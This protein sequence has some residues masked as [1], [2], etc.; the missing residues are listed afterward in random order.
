MSLTNNLVSIWSFNNS[1]NDVHGSNHGSAVGAT[2]DETNKKLGVASANVDG[3]DDYINCGNN[4]SVR[5]ASAITLMAGVRREGA[6][7][8]SLPGVITINGGTDVATGYILCLTSAGKVRFYI[9]NGSFVYAESNDVLTNGQWHQIFARW[10]G[11]EVALWIDNVKQTI[12]A[13]SAGVTYTGAN[14]LNIG[15]YNRQ[16]AGSYTDGQLDEC[17]L[18]NRALTTDEMTELYNSGNWREYPFYIEA[19]ITESITATETPSSNYATA[20]AQTETANATETEELSKVTL[21]DIIE[22]ISA[23]DTSY[24]ALLGVIM[25]SYKSL[26]LKSGRFRR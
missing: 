21:V 23:A 12:T 18:W 17:G 24:A 13:T 10:D 16:S 19:D 20:A 4:A 15:V 6:G 3:I 25:R 7:A 11:S 22:A 26:Y 9:W 8:G 5:P 2:F 14:E 1:W